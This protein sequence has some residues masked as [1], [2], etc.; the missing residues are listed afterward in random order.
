LSQDIENV[1]CQ[2]VT[3]G[4]VVFYGKKEE[5]EKDGKMHRHDS[6]ALTTLTNSRKPESK[7]TELWEVGYFFKEKD[8]RSGYVMMR[9]EK[10]ELSKD[11]LPTE[12]VVEYEITDKVQDLQLRYWDGAKWT[13]ERGSTSQCM[14]PSAVEISLVL[15]TGKPYVT[16]VWA[17][18]A[19]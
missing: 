16:E 19:Q 14:P 1:Y 7:E 3:N 2:P 8:D 6:L 10:R 18:N 11:S 15:D 13:D 9:R 5:I 12:G 4:N 17:R